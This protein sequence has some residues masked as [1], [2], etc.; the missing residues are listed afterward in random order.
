MCRSKGSQANAESHIIPGDPQVYPCKQSAIKP[1]LIMRLPSLPLPCIVHPLVFAQRCNCQKC[2]KRLTVVG[3]AV[4]YTR[5]TV[6][7]P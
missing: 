5:R 6:L 2:F 1:P 7:L 3:Y 4:D